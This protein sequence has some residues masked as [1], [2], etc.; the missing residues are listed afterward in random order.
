M[1]IDLKELFKND[2]NGNEKMYLTLLRALKNSAG[3]GFDYLK[4]KQSIQSMKDLGMDE[5]TVLKSAFATASVMGVTKPQ[6]IKSAQRY[7][8]VLSREQDEFATALKAQI[9]KNI[10]GRRVEAKKLE[11]AIQNNNHKIEELKRQNQAYQNKIDSVEEVVSEARVKI[12][13][14]RDSFKATLDTL[15]EQIED[16]IILFDKYL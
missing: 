3:D 14:T 13:A 2:I 16:D 9:S 4:F 1:T 5:E 11:I 15:S 6:L 7:K 10:D 8:G 12:E